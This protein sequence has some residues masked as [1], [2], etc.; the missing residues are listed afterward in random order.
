M[1][2]RNV[3]AR[4][5]LYFL[6][7]LEQQSRNACCAYAFQWEEDWQLPCQ[8]FQIGNPASGRNCLIQGAGKVVY[9]GLMLPAQL[10]DRR[11][12]KLTHPFAGYAKFSADLL[13]GSD[14][15]TETGALAQYT[16]KPPV[17]QHLKQTRYTLVERVHAG[18]CVFLCDNGRLVRAHF[19]KRRNQ[20]SLQF[21]TNPTNRRISH[22]RH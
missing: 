13:K 12:L 3:P 20:V 19:F 18:S 11:C 4:R 16:D 15:T 8:V 14:V 9:L 22:P 21:C 6:H 2:Q 10:E 5:L 1:I 17:P 7:Q